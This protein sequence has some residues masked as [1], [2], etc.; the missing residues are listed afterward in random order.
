M[1][2]VAS[3]LNDRRVAVENTLW[4]ATAASTAEALYLCAILNSATFTELARPFMSYGKD[5]RHFSKH[6]WQIPVPL[7]DPTD[8][9]HSRLSARGAQLEAAIG[10]LG[11][12]PGRHFAAVRRD[13][14]GFIAESEAGRDVE[15]LVE[16]LLS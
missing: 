16:E 11:L 6:I 4:W 2:L 7:Y 1:H 12:V 9:L 5:E 10:K 8:D 14:R 3:R 13:I 15:A